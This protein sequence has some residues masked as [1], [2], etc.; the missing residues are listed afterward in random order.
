VLL[1]TESWKNTVAMGNQ[2]YK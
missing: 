2:S 1:T